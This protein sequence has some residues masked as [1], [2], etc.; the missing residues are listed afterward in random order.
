MPFIASRLRFWHCLL[1]RFLFNLLG[2]HIWVVSLFVLIVFPV[3]VRLRITEGAVTGAV[4]M[5]HLF[6]Y[7][8]AD[9]ASVLNELILLVIGLGTA[10]IINIAYMPKADQT[11]SVAHKQKIESL[12]SDIFVN[13]AKHLRDNTV[14]WD[15]KE[16]LEVSEEI[17]RGAS[18]GETF[19]GE[20]FFLV[21]I[22]IGVCIST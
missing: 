12:F 6:A 22:L 13:I 20:Y 17:E 11:P 19:D 18:I 3:L 5:L 14:I 15:G 10:T 8:S 7:E 21:E 4:V 9:W 16:L 1:V 2:F